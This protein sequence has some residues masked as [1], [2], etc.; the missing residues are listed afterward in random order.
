MKC[1]LCKNKNFPIIVESHHPIEKQPVMICFNCFE[2]LAAI[3]FEKEEF[4]K[5]IKAHK[6]S[7]KELQPNRCE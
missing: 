3:N 4:R 2:H 5:T 1:A 7:R 6:D